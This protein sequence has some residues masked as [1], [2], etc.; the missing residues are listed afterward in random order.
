[1]LFHGLSAFPI[2]PADESGHVNVESLCR[3]LE[4]LERAGVDS[5]GLLGSTGSYMYLSRA[6]RRRTIEAARE[7]L[8]G[9]VPVIVSAGALRTGDAEDLARDAKRAGADGLLLAPVSYTPLTDD[10]VLQHYS[11]VA[12]A[13]DLP[14]CVYNNPGTTHFTIS[15]ALLA[16]MA[17]VPNIVAVKNPAQPLPEMRAVHQALE[18]QLP[19]GFAIGYSGDWNAPG[20]LLA[21]GAAWYSV[22]AGLLPVPS[23]KLARA[24]KVGNV[25]EVERIDGLFA[26]LFALFKEL[27]S[28][29]VV[30][31]AA[32]AMGLATTKPPLP[33]L[34]LST[35]DQD[36]I[37]TAISALDTV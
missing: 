31:A 28:Y 11:G 24:A 27:S 3:L 19:V 14:L 1:M 7:C 21:G 35:A 5:V 20:A 2:T 18:A 25:A 9:R 32:N 26:P 12:G 37:M 29:R 13:T 17:A 6:E 34:P 22:V 15:N 23:L 16:R 33:I 4:R 36:R 8:G 30:H 10:E